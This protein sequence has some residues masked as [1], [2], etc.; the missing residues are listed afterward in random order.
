[1]D[2]VTTSVLQNSVVVVVPNVTEILNLLLITGT[3]PESNE[4]AVVR[5]LLKK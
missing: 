1:M 2:V 5:P 3:G 4:I